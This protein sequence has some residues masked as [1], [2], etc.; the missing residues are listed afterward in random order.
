MDQTPGWRVSLVMRTKA[1]LVVVLLG[2]T[3]AAEAQRSPRLIPHDWIQETRQSESEPLRYRSPDGRV[4]L[5]L[6]STAAD[7][8]RRLTL[9]GAENERITYRRV[10]PRFIAVSGFRGDLIFYRKSNL[11]CNGT[12][13]HHITLD[14]PAED[15]LKMDR[16]VTRVAHSM[17]RFDKDCRG[18]PSTTSGGLVGIH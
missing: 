9:S 13:W 11:A 16:L 1:L 4:W 14:Y 17:N 10:T 15:K 5:T 12:R 7:K 8:R 2:W 6:Y 18:S 3:S